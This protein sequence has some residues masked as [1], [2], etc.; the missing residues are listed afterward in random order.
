MPG[1]LNRRPRWWIAVVQVVL[2]LVTLVTP[3]AAASAPLTGNQLIQVLR[4]Y[5]V[6]RGDET[7]NLN[8]DKPITRAEMI[9]IMVRAL[10]AEETAKLYKGFVVFDDA[11]GHWAE[12]NIAYASFKNLVKG[13]GDG[14]VRPQDNVTYAEALTLILRIVGKEP[15]TGDW[16]VN[17]IIA[18][19]E[20][21]IVPEGVNATNM[22]Q[23]AIRGLVFQSLAQAA[24]TV[25]TPDGR[26]HLQTYVDS[27]PPTLTVN[28]PAASTKDA[29]VTIS[30]TVQEAQYLTVNGNAINWVGSSFSTS[31]TLIYGENT[32]VVEASDYAGNKRTEQ[33]KINRV[34]PISSL[35]IT[36]PGKVRPGARETYT[37]TAKDSA[38]KV[39]ALEG[40]TAAVTG[41]IGTFD[42]AT[43]ILTAA[44][45]PAKGKI[46]LTT[47]T[48]TKSFDVEIMG[49]SAD[50]VRLG[51]R[52]VNNGQAVSVSR[53]MTIVVEI[54]DSNGQLVTT[55]YDRP[56]SLVATGLSNLN[57][58]PS[59][60]RTEAGLATFTVTTG[61]T[62]F[63]H[64]QAA[65]ASL[66]GSSYT[67]EFGTNLRVRLSTDP[68]SIT[69]GSSNNF[70][71]IRAT[72]VDENGN[73]TPNNTDSD[74]AI[75][76]F[77]NGTDGSLSDPYVRIFRGHSS[78]QQ[79]GDEGLYTVGA[80]NG[81]ISITGSVT[82][83]QRLTV[84]S[85]SLNTSLPII[86]AG[87]R[88]D[89]V[90]YQ[91]YTPGTPGIFYVRVVDGNGVVIPGS[92][93]LQLS[94]ETSNNETKTAGIPTGVSIT[95][96][97][98]G[99]NPINDGVAE[100]AANDGNDVIV[101]TVNGIAAF[102]V[103]YDKPGQVHVTVNPAPGST[104]AFSHDGTSGTAVSPG[105]TARS[106][107]LLFTQQ[108]TAVKLLA[109]S[110]LG[111]GHAVAATAPGR[112]V[113]LHAY[114]TNG[115]GNW[116]PGTTATFT[117]AKVGTGTA[118]SPVTTT[119]TAVD[120]K[121]TFTINALAV[122]EEEYRITANLTGTPQSLPVL[123][124]VQNTAPVAPSI[125]A[126]RGTNNG[127]PG[128][129]N[130]VGPND[131]HMEIE[132]N[133]DPAQKWATVR[134][135]TENSGSAIYISSPV[136]MNSSAPRITVPR[137]SLP[138]GVARYQVSVRNGYGEGPRS[139]ASSQVTK[140]VVVSNIAITSA[141]YQRSTN[142]LVVYGSGFTNTS[143]LINPAQLTIRD[144]S[145]GYT[146]S[147]AG[148]QA[149][150][151][152]WN[153]IT[154][155]LTGLTAVLLDLGDPNKFAGSDVTISADS[156]WYTR[157]NGEQS[158]AI[159]PGGVVGPMAAIK[160]V[161]YDRVNSR[162]YL[163]GEGFS[164]V[165]IDFSKVKLQAD[166]A[167]DITLNAFTTSRLS[168]TQWMITLN[169]TA[170]Q[171]LDANGGYTLNTLDGWAYEGTWTQPAV[172]GK[173]VYGQ[174][175][176]TSVTYDR[177]THTVTLNGS[178]FLNGTL[179]LANLRFINT[180]LSID[181][182]VQVVGP[183][184]AAASSD[185]QVQ[186]QLSAFDVL[187]GWDQNANIYLVG[188]AGWFTTSANRT[189]API[190]DRT[191]RLSQFASTAP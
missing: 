4:H 70:A 89:I 143:D 60:A 156:G 130:Y 29:N 163:N 90:A 151:N 152:N 35:E 154:F 79:G 150:I 103:N 63:V 16:P 97:D 65:T 3:V 159:T 59:V 17:V 120:G 23:P 138:N 9:T 34:P 122:G 153:Q 54:L 6:V 56:V 25:K 27:M 176:L 135:Y 98:T 101:R 136:D 173:T 124:Q 12:A 164:T 75:Q 8:L 99:L 39:V 64:L 71:R 116:T 28:R 142:Q 7:G 31:V 167:T 177:T 166:G 181:N 47:G 13:D 74:I 21:A 134:I 128:A 160:S 49:P 95:L 183:Q 104:V 68:T 41:S 162:L 112:P 19:S 22:N 187:E 113:T 158:A 51:F 62:G 132:L 170:V 165:N 83:T 85:T 190:L 110:D 94:V 78:S 5:N 18:S 131:T 40:V 32:I 182:T 2:L 33:I 118:T 76:V 107:S 67:A 72:L 161:V 127:I 169:S 36:G 172:T 141:K 137:D 119:A 66:V 30:G 191:M 149:T 77:A 186:F 96:G 115:Q 188:D 129:L 48:V 87:A 86:G 57:V 43:R 82:S 140:A 125:L 106:F 11:K 144:A 174:V 80:Q 20:L 69:L 168:D 184:P 26:T 185:N 50:G 88:F 109:D 148:A 37:I 108:P 105:I 92:Y 114:L 1:T 45:S 123:I 189:A 58:T 155:N 44:N 157:L 102:R 146:V 145:S 139:I 24:T 52:Q 178:G 100:G 133:R 180:D 15:T 46:T 175:A 81:T 147:L 121:A 117:L 10:G 179:N 14:R 84:D 61:A 42:M 73:P 38:G 91:P 126:I 53:P 93:A 111:T 55:D 171:A